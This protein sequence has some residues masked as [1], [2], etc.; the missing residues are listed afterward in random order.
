MMRAGAI[1]AGPLPENPGCPL[2]TFIFERKLLNRS[3]I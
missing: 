1:R 2:S 3:G